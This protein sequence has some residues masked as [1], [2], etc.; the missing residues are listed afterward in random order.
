MLALYLRNTSREA[1]SE[2][3]GIKEHHECGT[4]KDG[5]IY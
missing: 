3:S 1:M 4:C 5:G 2:S